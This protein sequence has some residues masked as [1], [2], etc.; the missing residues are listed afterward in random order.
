MC[1]A[2]F[3]Y[4]TYD[5]NHLLCELITTKYVHF[6]QKS[7]NMQIHFPQIQHFVKSYKTK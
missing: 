7:N 6:L 5:T 2:V 1:C 3:L 4:Y